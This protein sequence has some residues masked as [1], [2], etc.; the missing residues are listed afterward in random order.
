[1]LQ[2]GEIIFFQSHKNTVI[3]FHKG[4]NVI[5][6]SSDTGKSSILKSF[7]L[8]LNN[9]PSGDAYRS[10]FA[11]E[12]EPTSVALEFDDGWFVRSRLKGKN[13]YETEE[14]KFEALRTDV[15]ES[16]Q[17][18]ANMAEYNVQT[19]F[20]K[21]FML[22]DTPGERAKKLNEL[23]GLEIIDSVFK[24]IN[25]N[26]LTHKANIKS[27]NSDINDM[28]VELDNLSYLDALEVA[29]NKLSSDIDKA[30]SLTGR[31]NQL[32]SLIVSI[33][34]IDKQINETS[35]I[36]AIE[37]S[38]KDLKVL[39]EIET[40]LGMKCNNLMDYCTSIKEITIRIKGH[41]EFLKIETP[42]VDLKKRY[43]GLSIISDNVRNLDFLLDKLSE[44]DC[45]ITME[46]KELNVLIDTYSNKL[47]ESPTCPLCMSNIDS[48]T[49]SHIQKQL[50]V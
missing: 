49:I 41:Q 5:I 21:Y 20:Q 45:K 47:K 15:P 9:K 40:N 36:L 26:L 50:G 17:N 34:D 37:S 1:M 7:L 27:L 28:R 14:G 13:Y 24:K 6:G 31:A 23:V 32:D 33:L 10:W 35:Q 16:I 12:D 30:D 3:E 4:M 43:L 46:Q 8:A 38:V 22:Q 11:P 29:I 25:G 39:L 44:I 19:Q 18:I 48:K 2:S 42:V